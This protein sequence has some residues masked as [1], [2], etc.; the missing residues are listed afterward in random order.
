VTGH[1][2]VGGYEGPA[3][4]ATRR[5]QPCRADGKDISCDSDVRFDCQFSRRYAHRHDRSATHSS[6]W[7]VFE[8]RSSG[9]WRGPHPLHVV[10]VLEAVFG[11]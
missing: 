5:L 8:Y 7:F 2:H 6:V 9:A 3:G 11:M 10:D 1:E 4:D